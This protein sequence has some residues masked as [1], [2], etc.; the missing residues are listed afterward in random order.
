V[1]LR[2]YFAYK[3]AFRANSFNMLHRC[4]KLFQ[5]KMVDNQIKCESNT[6]KW[7]QMNQ[8][9]LR[10]DSYQGLIDHLAR[11]A[12]SEHLTTGTRIIL[13]STFMVNNFSFKYNSLNS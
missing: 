9:K 6:L 1:T 12:Q 8:Q 10:C 3:L 4:G 11:R 13:P 5:E 7:A 2:E